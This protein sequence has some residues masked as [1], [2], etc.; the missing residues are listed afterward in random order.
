LGA[1]SGKS[2]AVTIPHTLCE[3]ATTELV[4]TKKIY[5]VNSVQN[6]LLERE[7]ESDENYFMVNSLLVSYAGCDV[8]LY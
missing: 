6:W 2:E 4:E 7:S 1:S 8:K 3:R 5:D